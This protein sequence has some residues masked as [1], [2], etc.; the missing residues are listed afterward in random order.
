LIKEKFSHEEMTPPAVDSGWFSSTGV[1]HTTLL[2]IATGTRNDDHIKR[3]L[4]SLEEDSRRESRRK[5][6]VLDI[7]K[8]SNLSRGA[9]TTI[10]RAEMANRS[11]VTTTN[12]SK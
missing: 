9:A 11:T 1:D 7:K 5:G 6:T 4:V 3:S 12:T 10:V 8:E 2:N